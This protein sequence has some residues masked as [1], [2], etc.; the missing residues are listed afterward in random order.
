[1]ECNF[2]SFANFEWTIPS[3]T[4]TVTICFVSIAGII[5]N[6]ICC[7]TLFREKSTM[8]N[9]ITLAILDT[10]FLAAAVLGTVFTIPNRFGLVPDNIMSIYNF[11]FEKPNVLM[12]PQRMS[13]LF[14]LVIAL[15]R[16][17]CISKPLMYRRRIAETWNKRLSFFLVVISLLM[18]VPEV[19]YDP[20]DYQPPTST[21]RMQLD[22]GLNLNTSN[23]FTVSTASLITETTTRNVINNTGSH[24]ITEEKGKHIQPTVHTNTDIYNVYVFVLTAIF[25]IIPNILVVLI[26]IATSLMLVSKSKI[27]RQLVGLENNDRNRM[28]NAERKITIT[29]HLL[30]I[31]YVV[32]MLPAYLGFIV[33]PMLSSISDISNQTYIL[34]V[35]LA[36]CINSSINTIVFYVCGAS[37]RKTFKEVVRCDCRC[38]RTDSSPNNSSLHATRMDFQRS[39]QSASR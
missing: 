20:C 27:R 38:D 37:F 32:C 12:I 15:K 18:H 16:I 11:L 26:N 5:G 22:T 6:V 30:C 9:V 17:I 34:V 24:E 33:T 23:L 8:E 13:G 25:G 1:M 3:T 19:V 14:I 7:V 4:L 29:L 39:T 36:G 10:F 2:K 31:C 21:D 35:L 28:I